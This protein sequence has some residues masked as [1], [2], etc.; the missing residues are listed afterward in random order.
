MFGKKLSGRWHLVRTRMQGK[1][2]NWLLMKSRDDFAR[3]PA[4]MRT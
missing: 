2:P 3:A 4:R 1:Q